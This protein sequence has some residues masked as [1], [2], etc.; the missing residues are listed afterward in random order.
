MNSMT[1][2]SPPS[3]AVT[4]S[5]DLTYPIESL[6]DQFAVT[7]SPTQLLN[8]SPYRS[9]FAA[10]D[11]VAASPASSTIRS[12]QTW[13][14]IAGQGHVEHEASAIENQWPTLPTDHVEVPENFETALRERERLRRLD[15]EQRGLAWSA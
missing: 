2:D 3:V 11:R 15:L 14:T 1:I 4:Q 6:A 12:S 9:G 7:S 8:S 5:V 10:N 13:A